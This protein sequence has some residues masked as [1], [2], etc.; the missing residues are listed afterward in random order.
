[1]NDQPEISI[2]IVTYQASSL[3][4][5]CLRSLQENCS[6][7]Y[8]VIVVDNGSTDGVQQM[9]DQE[10]PGTCFIQND[11]NAG[12]TRPMNQALRQAKAD[13]LMQLNPD[14][15]ILPKALDTLVQFLERSPRNGH[16]RSKGAKQRH[17]PAKTLP[18]WRAYPPGGN[19]LFYRSILA[20]SKFQAAGWLSDE[21]HG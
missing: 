11:H 15:I 5:D 20:L 3:L 1:M 16:L 13:F 14:T 19:C 17:D 18:A 6:L 7:S 4:R 9:L 10:F 2:C 8:E 12:Y 21:L